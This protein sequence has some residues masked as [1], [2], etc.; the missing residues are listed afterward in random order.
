MSEITMLGAAIVLLLVVVIMLLRSIR[1]TPE[2]PQCQKVGE[3]YDSNVSEAWLDCVCH[4]CGYRWR[5]K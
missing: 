4:D 2:C 1:I 3:I 5:I